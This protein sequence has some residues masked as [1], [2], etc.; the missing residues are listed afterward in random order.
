MA[1]LI[2]LLVEVHQMNN[3]L[4]N[5]IERYPA[6]SLQFIPFEI[7][8]VGGREHARCIVHSVTLSSLNVHTHDIL[9]SAIT[10]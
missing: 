3:G 4:S 8:S 5:S 7:W 2:H 6:H 9:P 10:S 1:W